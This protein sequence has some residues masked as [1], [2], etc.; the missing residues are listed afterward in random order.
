[1]RRDIRLVGP[2]ATYSV[3]G[4]GAIVPAFGILGARSGVPVGSHVVR[5]GE[6]LP[7]ATP[8]K[9]SGFRMVRDDVVVLQSAGGG[10]YGDPLDR[11]PERVLEDVR[12]GYVTLAR[13]HAVYGVVLDGDLAID[14]P[15]TEERRR[16]LRDARVR[17]AAMLTDE[18]QYETTAVSRHRV[19]RMNPAD[20]ERAGFR[21]E[22]LIELV[23]RLV[24]LRAW[25]VVDR[26]VPA[27]RVPVDTLA[28]RV[29]AVDDLELLEVRPLA[30][31]AR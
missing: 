29:L 3:L 13:A 5:H 8:G 21:A 7:F 17:L 9:V 24:P 14:V 11:E 1:M 15:A 28:A 12:E 22:D 18:P 10:G 2:E 27:G 6:V 16:A 4:D 31:H 26:A 20:A 23:G 25:V 19:C 30:R